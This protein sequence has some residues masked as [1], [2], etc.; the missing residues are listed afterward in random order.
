MHDDRDITGT[1]GVLATLVHSGLDLKLLNALALYVDTGQTDD[2]RGVSSTM[3]LL[4]SAAIE[5]IGPELVRK[6]ALSV[7]ATSPATLTYLRSI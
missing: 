2:I 1:S 6:L 5:A 3:V 7:F 4:A